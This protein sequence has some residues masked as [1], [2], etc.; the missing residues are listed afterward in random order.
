MDVWM[1]LLF[2][3]WCRAFLSFLIF[4]FNVDHVSLSHVCF[5]ALLYGVIAIFVFQIF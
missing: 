1:F 5:Y 3:V 4:H 2:T